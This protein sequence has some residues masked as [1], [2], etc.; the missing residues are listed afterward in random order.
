MRDSPGSR[1]V[2]SQP[3]VLVVDDEPANIETLAAALEDDYDVRFGMTGHEGL[4]LARTEP[5]PDVVLLDVMLPDLNGYD[6]CTQLRADDATAHVPVI[7]VTALSD[8]QEEAKGFEIGAVDYIVK[9]FS[10]TIV[11]ARV[12]T[13]LEMKRSRESL[14]RLAGT[15]AL[16]GLPNRRHFDHALLQEIQRQRRHGAPLSLIIVDVDHF[17]RY[18]DRYGHP[19]GDECLRKVASAV[20]SVLKRPSDL[21]ARIGGEEFGSLLPETNAVEA[22]ALAEQIRIAVA[23]LAIA[24]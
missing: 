17:K 23:D 4:A 24:H 11:R 3:V 14:Q 6:I 19:A 13:Q 2:T 1:I 16:T 9:P 22:A 8:P 20:A 10:P 7:F 21:A 15:D 5:V 12:R 18:N